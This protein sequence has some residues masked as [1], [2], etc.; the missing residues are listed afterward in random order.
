MR[1]AYALCELLG[2]IYEAHNS[3]KKAHFIN[4]LGVVI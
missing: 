2:I 4:T 1:N 3:H